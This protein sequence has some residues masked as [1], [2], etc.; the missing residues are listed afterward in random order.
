MKPRMARCGFLDAPRVDSSS[1]ATS[2]SGFAKGLASR[3]ATK[4]LDNKAARH[5]ALRLTMNYDRSHAATVQV[6]SV[7]INRQWPVCDKRRVSDE[8][9]AFP[10]DE[11]LCAAGVDMDRSWALSM[12]RTRALPGEASSNVQSSDPSMTSRSVAGLLGCFLHHPRATTSSGSVE[13]A[14]AGTGRKRCGSAGF[15]G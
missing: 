12:Q 3:A 1:S 7:T 9:R 6:L 11:S 14:S 5:L 13:V 15:I 4:K 2:S 8:L 10:A